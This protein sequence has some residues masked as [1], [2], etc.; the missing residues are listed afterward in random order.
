M[1]LE[2][3]GKQGGT[4]QRKYQVAYI[5]GALVSSHAML[6]SKKRI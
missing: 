2:G 1:R 4:T 6:E 3:R 5:Q